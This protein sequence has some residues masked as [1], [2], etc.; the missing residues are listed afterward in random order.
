MSRFP[1]RP[2]PRQLLL[3]YPRHRAT[4]VQ[5]RAWPGSSPG[6]E[7]EQGLPAATS[8]TSRQALSSQSDFGVA[9]KV[10]HD[11][12][13]R[14]DFVDDTAG[15]AGPTS[16]VLDVTFKVGRRGSNCIPRPLFDFS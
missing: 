4:S 3:S 12:S 11:I 5:P 7:C 1:L 16:R 14:L 13:G 15:L 2:G 9:D 6:Q 10:T 8:P